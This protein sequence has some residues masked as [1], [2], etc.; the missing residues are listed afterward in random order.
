MKMTLVCFLTAAFVALT[1]VPLEAAKPRKAERAENR[2]AARMLGRF[3]R[4]HDGSLDTS[5]AQRVRK[6][7]DA[8]KDL[9]SDKNGELSDSEISAAKVAKRR[10]KGGKKNP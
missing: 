7:F 3:D 2:A 5:E 8:L 10:G 1:S 6:A 9:D 4:N